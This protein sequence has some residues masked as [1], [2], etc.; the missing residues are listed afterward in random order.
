M[1]ANASGAKSVY[2]WSCMGKPNDINSRG[3]PAAQVGYAQS[4]LAD[5]WDSRFCC[6]PP[7]K[8]AMRK[9]P[10]GIAAHRLSRPT[11]LDYSGSA[12]PGRAGHPE[13]HHHSV[14]S[15]GLHDI[16]SVSLDV[17]PEPVDEKIV[18]AENGLGIG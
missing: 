12:Y 10:K 5:G 3:A 11:G 8:P 13:C 15:A 14:C 4:L 7:P 16:A 17:L 2:P 6:L 18:Y 1:A 9:W